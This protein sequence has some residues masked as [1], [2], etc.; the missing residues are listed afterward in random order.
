HQKCLVEFRE[1]FG[2]EWTEDDRLVVLPP[3]GGGD[4]A[5][6]VAFRE[7][8]EAQRVFVNLRKAMVEAVEFVKRCDPTIPRVG[9][10]NPTV[11]FLRWWV[12]MFVEPLL[13]HAALAVEPRLSDVR[14]GRAALAHD[15][16]RLDLLGV[17][18]VLETRELAIVSLLV[19]NWPCEAMPR[20]GLTV[21]SVL[22]REANCVR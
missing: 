7:E 6:D 12:P 18:R 15:L 20:E 8:Q 19:G 14:T 13:K 4:W 2:R 1:R 5:G 16:D 10:G 17:G 9:L 21:A 11:S 22:E 3:D